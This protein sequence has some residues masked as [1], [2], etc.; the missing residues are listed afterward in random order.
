MT[1]SN[2]IYKAFVS[3]TF[4]DLKEHRA[5]VI[6]SLRNA[7]FFVDPMET[8]QQTATSPRSCLRIASLAVTCASYSSRSDEGMCPMVK[9]KASRSWNTTAP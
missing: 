2:K 8:G 9:L 7:G 5:H 1:A 4:V 3:S 6:N